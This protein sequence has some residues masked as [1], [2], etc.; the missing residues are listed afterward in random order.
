MYIHT[1]ANMHMQT[2]I[3]TYGYVL[4]CIHIHNTSPSSCIN[5]SLMQVSNNKTLSVSLCSSSAF[6]VTYISL[7]QIY[8]IHRS[9]PLTNLIFSHMWYS[10]TGSTFETSLLPRQPNYQINSTQHLS[11]RSHH[12]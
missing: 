11:R 9:K 6:S 12:I 10:T 4:T 2:W 5:Y 3:D 1:C 8:L 7:S